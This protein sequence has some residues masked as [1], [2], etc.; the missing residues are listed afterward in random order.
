MAKQVRITGLEC[1]EIDGEYFS[2]NE[3][4][5]EYWS[6]SGEPRVLQE[7][8]IAAWRMQFNTGRGYT[9]QG[10]EI[11][12]KILS[13]QLCPLVDRDVY[14]LGFIDHSRG[15]CGTLQVAQLI[16]ASVMREYDAGR[17][18]GLWPGAYENLGFV[19]RV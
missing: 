6:D 2:W 13:W 7:G 9:P 8:E 14:K 19:G 17:Y 16:P 11:E 5:G 1:L 15:I 4:F 12:A 3:S 18:E 10:Q